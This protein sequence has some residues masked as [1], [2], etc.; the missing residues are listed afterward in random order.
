MGYSQD[1]YGYL[2]FRAFGLLLVIVLPNLFGTK[3][4]P[5]F[6]FLGDEKIFKTLLDNEHS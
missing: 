1:I 3:G 5:S 6:R 4:L 2:V